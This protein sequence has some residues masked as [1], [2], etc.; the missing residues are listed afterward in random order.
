MNP[1]DSEHNEVTQAPA[2]SEP[3]PDPE[4]NL[5]SAGLSIKG[6]PEFP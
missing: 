1:H 6:I 4:L 5:V 3:H 2:E